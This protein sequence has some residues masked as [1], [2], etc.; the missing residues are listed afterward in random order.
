[1]VGK[2]CAELNNYFCKAED[3]H[4][5]RFTIK[6]GAI[7]PVDFLQEGQY[8]RIIGSVLNDGIYQ[9]PEDKLRDEVFNGSVWAMKIDREFL[10][11]AEEM[12]TLSEQ[13]DK[14]ALES[15]VVGSETYPNG[16]SYSVISSLPVALQHQYKAIELKKRRWRKLN[17]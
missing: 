12:K 14:V 11:L 2:L 3:K 5:G 4:N 13:I 16:Y 15:S 6:S 7:S 9:H 1:M 10:A 8:Y 17:V